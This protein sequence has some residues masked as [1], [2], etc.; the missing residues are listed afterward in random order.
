MKKRL[1][2]LLT[3]FLANTVYAQN[4][5]DKNPEK[6]TF[7]NGISVTSHTCVNANGDYLTSKL[8]WQR[9]NRPTFSHT[10]NASDYVEW[11]HK[12]INP[13]LVL[14]DYYAERGGALILVNWQPEKPQFYRLD[15]T[16]HEESGLCARQ[17][18]TEIH[19][20]RCAF[21][22][23]FGRDVLKLQAHAKGWRVLNPQVLPRF[24]D[25]DKLP[26]FPKSLYPK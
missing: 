14:V 4:C 25:W 17:V 3:L 2:L 11:T 15:Y 19:I 8:V 6:H 22:Q 9:K 18:K 12:Q 7:P 24:T 10:F 23:N 13:H 16:G 26:E 5:H 21:R 1:I 20:Q